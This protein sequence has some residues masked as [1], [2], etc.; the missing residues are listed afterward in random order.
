MTNHSQMAAVVANAPA[1][2][3][4]PLHICYVITRSDVMGG[5]S[6][7]LLDLAEGMQQA[8]HQVTILIGGEGV[9]NQRARARGLQ[10]VVLQHL[11][12]P[13]HPYHDLA[14]WFELR[15]HFNRLQPDIIHLHSS[16]AGL[17]GRL[18][19]VKLGIPVLFTAH[20][21]AFTE[22]VS[23]ASS[24]LY[25]LL[26]RWVAPLTDRIITV[27]EYDRQRALQLSVGSADLLQTVHNGM[28]A[29]A[30][31][32][33]AANE[34]SHQHN[35]LVMVARFEQP[36]DQQLLL[37]ALSLVKGD[38]QLQLIGDGPL[39]E[40]ARQCAAALALSERVEFAGA[41]NDVAVQLGR[42]GIFVLLSRWEGLPLTILEAMRAGLAVVASRVGGVPELV[43]DG[44]TGLLV[45]N[46]PS[47]VASALQQLLD[48]VAVQRQFGQ[49]GQQRFE[50]YFTFSRMLAQTSA[51]Y[52]E[53]TATVESGR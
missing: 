46:E 30:A 43:Q 16:K 28:P 52:R 27:S 50:E 45:D 5:A 17:I 11:V 21:W 20:G 40:D 37:Q 32:A 10:I 33:T 2:S 31:A 4:S 34:A 12:R 24:L 44:V 38:W 9:V 48:D 26:E 14:C 13:I 19:A 39:L 47:A 51:I 29:V 42:A 3:A 49:A 8:G 25:R 35:R 18:A 36:K 53:L 23:A 7:H 15:R 22:G 41:R 6:V 1:A